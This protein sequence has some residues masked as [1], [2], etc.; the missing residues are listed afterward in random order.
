AIG[1]CVGLVDTRVTFAGSEPGLAALTRTKLWGG[2]VEFT[3]TGPKASAWGWMFKMSPS[4]VSESATLCGLSLVTVVVIWS[5]SAK[6][7]GL[8]FAG[9]WGVRVRVTLPVV[10]ASVG[11]KVPPVGG[12]GLALMAPASRAA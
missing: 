6:A 4:G 9:N 7:E 3:G 2:D 5:V 8:G 1:N 10:G 11:L 12:K